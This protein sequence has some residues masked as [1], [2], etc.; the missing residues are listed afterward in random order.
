[1][2]PFPHH[3]IQASISV[4]QATARDAQEL[5]NLINQAYGS[6]SSWA[7]ADH[8]PQSQRV[9]LHEL[10]DLL[11]NT[12]KHL[13]VATITSCGGQEKMVGCIQLEYCKNC[14]G[15][16]LPP[17]SIFLS[18]FA[19]HPDHQGQGIGRLLFQRALDV[20]VEWWSDELEAA[21]L[22]VMDQRQAIMNWY[23]KLGFE[24]TG[25]K[26][27][28]EGKLYHVLRKSILAREVPV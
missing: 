7:N 25:A 13:L 26:C 17:Q 21:Y 16:R 24:S 2:P 9:N 12:R 14:P 19:T 27:E 15:C 11:L 23:M 10:N 18:L 1:M 6:T 8:T 5:C 20:A 3:K 22:W 28:T 4:R